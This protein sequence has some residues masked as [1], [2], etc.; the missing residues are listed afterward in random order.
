MKKLIKIFIEDNEIIDIRSDNFTKDEI[1]IQITNLTNLENEL[2]KYL[3]SE[4]QKK[5]YINNNI[6]KPKYSLY[7]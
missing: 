3:Y 5:E 6:Y 7:K 4:N 2:N 1:E